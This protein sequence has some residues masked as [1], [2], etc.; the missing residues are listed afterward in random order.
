VFGFTS[1][2][3]TGAPHEILPQPGDTFTILDKWMDL[4]A[5]GRVAQVADNLAAR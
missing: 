2:D 5:Q 4:D 1:E 3:G